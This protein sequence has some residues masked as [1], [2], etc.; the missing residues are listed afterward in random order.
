[1]LSKDE[2]PFLILEILTIE[3]EKEKLKMDST[4]MFKEWTKEETDNLEREQIIK[5]RDAIEEIKTR[6]AI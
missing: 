3:F 4:P 6:E 2:F 5:N 1:L